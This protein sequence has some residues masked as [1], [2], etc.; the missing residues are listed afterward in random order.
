MGGSDLSLNSPQ[1]DPI[2]A[3]SLAATGVPER[4]NYATGVLLGAEDFDTEGEPVF[5]EVPALTDEALQAVLHKII[6][7]MMKLLTRRGCS[8]RSRAKPTWSTTTAIRTR[9]AYSR[10][11]MGS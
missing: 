2:V 10:E 4:V 8:S 7:R 3:E 6:T 9:P 11:P 1:T 5:G